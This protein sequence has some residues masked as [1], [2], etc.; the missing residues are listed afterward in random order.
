VPGELGRE[1][2]ASQEALKLIKKTNPKALETRNGRAQTNY[3]ATKGE[4][5]L[6]IRDQS[7][8]TQSHN[9]H[10]DRNICEVQR[11]QPGFDLIDCL[12]LAASKETRVW[13]Y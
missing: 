2:I 13:M 11:K 12:T 8:L 7:I 9:Q 6:P 10:I 4:D 3:S 5:H 1:I